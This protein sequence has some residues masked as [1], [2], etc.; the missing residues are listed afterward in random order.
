MLALNG[1]LLPLVFLSTFR[2]R[3]GADVTGKQS[4]S[5]LASKA[6]DSGL[7]SGFLGAKSAPLPPELSG[8]TIRGDTRNIQFYAG[9]K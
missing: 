2:G 9:G 5:R 4:N 7:G 3:E 8:G 6:F 1:R